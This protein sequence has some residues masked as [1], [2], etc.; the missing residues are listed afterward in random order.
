VLSS[1]IAALLS[2]VATFFSKVTMDYF[3]TKRADSDKAKVR[4][5]ESAYVDIAGQGATRKSTIERLRDGK[6]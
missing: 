6:F 2:F 1:A 4:E 3:A 5:K